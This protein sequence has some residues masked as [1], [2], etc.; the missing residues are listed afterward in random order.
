ML[1]YSWSKHMHWRI[2]SLQWD[3][4]ILS[5]IDSFLLHTSYAELEY[6]LRKNKY[7]SFLKS[8]LKHAWALL[9]FEYVLSNQYFFMLKAT[10]TE[11]G[12]VFRK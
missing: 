12:Y 4:C 9:V 1:N 2:M 5:N 10:K 8:F 6:S 11:Y 3:N 7:L